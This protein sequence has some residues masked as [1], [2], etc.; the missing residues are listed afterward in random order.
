VRWRRVGGSSE[1]EQLESFDMDVG[2]AWTIER[3]AEQRTIS[4]IVAGGRRG[5]RELP[6]E[7]RRA[8]ETRGRTAVEGVLDREDPPR[9]IIV[10][11]SGLSERAE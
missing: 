5:S 8:I 6:E 7:S 11:I 10:S 3:D 2:W 9:Y 1:F 4:V